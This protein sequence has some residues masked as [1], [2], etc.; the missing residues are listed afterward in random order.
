MQTNIRSIIDMAQGAVKEQ[1]DYEMS[2]I[3]GNIM[4]PNT[5]PTKKRSLTVQLVFTPNADRQQIAVAATAKS[6]LEPTNPVNISL[7]V[8]GDEN[9]EV[10]AVEMVPQI[11]GQLDVYS[12]QQGEPATLR[13][14]K[15]A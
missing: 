1:I 12:G 7:Y 6:K 2:H 15:G 8:T 9:G 10:T 11:P 14:I 5:S 3:L 4:D 13:L